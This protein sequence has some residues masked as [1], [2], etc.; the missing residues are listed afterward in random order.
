MSRDYIVSGYFFLSIWMGKTK[1]NIT[2][3]TEEQQ[4]LRERAVVVAVIRDGQPVEQA[5]EFLAEL[6]FLAETADIVTVRR[7]TQRLPQP[8]SRI[9]VGPGKLEEIAMYC[10]ENEIDRPEDI[11]IRT[12]AN[13]SKLKVAIINAIDRKVALDD[14]AISKGVE[15]DEL[16]DDIESIVYSGTKLNIDYFLEEILDEEN[17]F[18]I[19]DYFKNSDTDNIDVAIEE[20]RGEYSEEEIRLVRVKFISEMG[21]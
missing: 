14:L 13:K 12:V 6:E 21:N 17:L 10:E 7:F 19:Y 9:Y 4:D 18:E 1:E 11:R 16:L 2:P 5:E 8:S 20:L 15:F 3:Q